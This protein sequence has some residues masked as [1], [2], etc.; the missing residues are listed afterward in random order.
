LFE[1]ENKLHLKNKLSKQV[2]FRLKGQFKHI[3]DLDL[4]L[5][6]GYP[7]IKSLEE[8]VDIGIYFSDLNQFDGS[9]EM[10]VNKML[11]D[12]NLRKQFDQVSYTKY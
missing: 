2:R 8:M 12:E 7:I 9:G 11:N 10:M 3:P 5:F 4:I 6:L 1:I